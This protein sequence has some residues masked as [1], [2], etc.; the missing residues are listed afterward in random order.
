LTDI[1]PG[2]P[3]NA[4]IVAQRLRNRIIECLDDL[5]EGY[6]ALSIF[7]SAFQAVCAATPR[8][9]DEEAFIATGIPAALAPVAAEALAVFMRRGRFDEAVIQPD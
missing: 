2:H 5:S 4:R 8:G 9:M 1:S 6:A 7:L 3:D